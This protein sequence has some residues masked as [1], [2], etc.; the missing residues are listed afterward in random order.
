[1]EVVTALYT[2]GY[3]PKVVNYVY[4][5]GGRDTLPHEVEQVYRELA[6]VDK[7]GVIQPVVRYLTV[8]E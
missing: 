8:R 5:I 4:G 1:L 7:T 3:A 2:H 6:E